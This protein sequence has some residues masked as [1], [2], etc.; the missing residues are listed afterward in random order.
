MLR[1]AVVLVELDLADL[2]LFV[3]AE[4]GDAWLTIT[5]AAPNSAISILFIRKVLLKVPTVIR[6]FV[7]ATGRHL[8][9]SVVAK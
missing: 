8:R 3:A 5:R 4:A 9:A 7:D 1:I 2:S 6:D